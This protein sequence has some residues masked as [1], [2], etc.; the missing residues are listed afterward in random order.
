MEEAASG[1][2][3]IQYPQMADC[4]PQ[5]TCIWEWGVKTHGRDRPRGI[6][7]TVAVGSPPHKSKTP[8]ILRRGCS[9]PQEGSALKQPSPHETQCLDLSPGYCLVQCRINQSCGGVIDVDQGGRRQHGDRGLFIC[10]DIKGFAQLKRSIKNKQAK[11]L[12]STD[13]LKTS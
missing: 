6:L 7:P 9:S 12:P 3:L 1:T 4:K 11:T 10:K 8:V 13:V 5:C 2:D